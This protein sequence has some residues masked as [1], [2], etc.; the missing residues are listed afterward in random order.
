MYYLVNDIGQWFSHQS[1][2]NCKSMTD[3]LVKANVL[4]DQRRRFLC[5]VFAL[6]GG[7]TLQQQHGYTRKEPQEFAKNNDIDFHGEDKEVATFGRD[8]QPKHF[9]RV[10]WESDLIDCESI[11]KYTVDGRNK[12]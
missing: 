3:P 4:N 10:L 9:L 2:G 8:R 6:P 12:G 1:N 7:V 11:D 5:S